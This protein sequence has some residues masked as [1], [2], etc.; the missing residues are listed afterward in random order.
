VCSPAG[1]Y[2]E[3]E[4]AEGDAAGDAELAQRHAAVRRVPPRTHS[5]ADDA[6]CTAHLSNVKLVSIY[7]VPASELALHAHMLDE[8]V[9]G[10]GSVHLTRR[11]LRTVLNMQEDTQVAPKAW[12]TRKAT[13]MQEA[14]RSDMPSSW[15]YKVKKASAFPGMHPAGSIISEASLVS[16]FLGKENRGMSATVQMTSKTRAALV[17]H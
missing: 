7:K 12:P 1:W 8:P 4:E 16:K 11:H 9:C 5:P 3:D 17:D 14:A 15:R 13:V 2:P 6:A 10:S